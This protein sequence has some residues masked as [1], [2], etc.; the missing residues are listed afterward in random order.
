MASNFTKAHKKQ[1]PVLHHYKKYLLQELKLAQI[2]THVE[3]MEDFRK[4][5]STVFKPRNDISSSPACA[6]S[7]GVFHQIMD[8][9]AGATPH[10]K[11]EEREVVP[12][13]WTRIKTKSAQQIKQN[14]MNPT[15]FKPRENIPSSPVCGLSSTSVFHQAMDFSADS[16]LHKKKEKQEVSMYWTRIKTKSAQQIKQNTMDPTTF[17]P[18]EDISS[19]PVCGLSSTNV[20]HQVMDFS[21]DATLHKKKEKQEVSMYWTRIKT[22]SAQQ[23]KQNTMDPTT[24]KPREDISSSPVCGLSSTNVFHQVMDFSAD[25][26]LHK[27]EEKQEVPMYWTRIKTKSAQQSKQNTMDPT[28]LAPTNFKPREEI[29]STPV[30]GLSNSSVFHQVMDFSA[31]AILHKK[32]EKQEVP[33]NWTRIKTKSAQQSKQNTMDP[34]DLAPTNFKPREEISSTPVCGLSNS[35]IFHQVMDFSADAILHKKKEKQEVPMYWTRIKTKSAQQIKQNTVDTT[36]LAPTNFKPRE[37]ISSTPVCGLSNSSVFHQVMDFSADA[38]LHKKEEKQEVPMNWTR[39]KT[40]S[41][42]QIKQN[43]MD[44][45]NF[46]PTRNLTPTHKKDNTTSKR[47]IVDELKGVLSSKRARRKKAA[48][49]FDELIGRFVT[50]EMVTEPKQHPIISELNKIFLTNEAA[51]KKSN[52]PNAFDERTPAIAVIQGLLKR[53]ALKE[54]RTGSKKASK[55]V[56]DKFDPV[57]QE[58]FARRKQQFVVK[59][60]RERSDFCRQMHEKANTV[61][62][63]LSTK[64]V[65]RELTERAKDKEAWCE[66]SNM[67]I[68]DLN[69]RFALRELSESFTA[70]GG[71]FTAH[72]ESFT[73]H[74]EEE[75]QEEKLSYVVQGLTRKFMLRELKERVEEKAIDRELFLGKDAH[76]AVQYQLLKKFLIQDLHARARALEEFHSKTD[77][78]LQDLKE[79]FEWVETQ[80]FKQLVIQDLADRSE[81]IQESQVKS[82]L[83]LVELLKKFVLDELKERSHV[84]LDSKAK[85]AGVLEELNEELDWVSV[86]EPIHS[87]GMMD[88]V[89]LQDRTEWDICNDDF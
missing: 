66:K 84:A 57:I 36:N 4:A 18:R 20:F 10:K 33:M 31:D 40:K 45:T 30:C 13:Y 52:T 32:E 51:A 62:H 44:P 29:L 71:S 3:A 87:T 59:E 1:G 88:W 81:A 75:L 21:A 80:E 9:S 79:R 83:V 54:L 11:K 70:Q 15:D 8:F 28:D 43:T 23:S 73:A 60:F 76:M 86:H 77:L 7:I 72:E 55:M 38:I 39:I 42:Q 26:T 24:F 61:I 37:E 12:M 17:K 58:V 64:F 47:A 85:T 53:N 82:S 65:L 56:L 6:L 50:R 46:V 35:S 25:A 27:K 14:T 67:I 2:E 19:S 34:T 68:N 89:E 63:E 69:Y 49:I 78:V 48:S 16:T 41:A 5:A 74:H 22:K